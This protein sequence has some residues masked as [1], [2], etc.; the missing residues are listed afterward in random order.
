MSAP[1]QDDGHGAHI[2]Q[3]TIFMKCEHPQQ[4]VHQACSDDALR[5]QQSPQLGY[6]PAASA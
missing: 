1:V 6:S 3:A 4:E 5:S 2:C